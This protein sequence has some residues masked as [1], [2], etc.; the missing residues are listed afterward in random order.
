MGEILEKSYTAGASIILGSFI[1]VIKEDPG[2]PDR[3]VSLGYIVEWLSNM[4]EK[5]EED[6]A[7]I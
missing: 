1:N 3:V 2:Y 5:L 4:K 7:E 6:N